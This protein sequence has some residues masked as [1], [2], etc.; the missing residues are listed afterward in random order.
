MSSAHRDRTGLALWG[1][2]DAEA[3]IRGCSR[4]FTVLVLGGLLAPLAGRLPVIGPCW[5]SAVAVAAFAVGGVRVG[6]SEHPVVQ[7]IVAAVSSYLLVL[8][9]VLAGGGGAAG[10]GWIGLTAA[11]ALAVGA[12]A[13]FAG[14][15]RRERT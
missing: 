9:L 5:L 14:A 12:A 6:G 1:G 11:V 8:P 13:G 10:L 15:R 4:G 3:L 7:G 2:I